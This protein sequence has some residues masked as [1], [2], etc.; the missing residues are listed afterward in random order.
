[1]TMESYLCF[2]LRPPKR[3][4]DMTALAAVKAASNR[5]AIERAQM[6][7]RSRSPALGEHANNQLRAA[8]IADL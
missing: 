2:F 4:L 6:N 5:V 1:M 7:A 8:G 3:F